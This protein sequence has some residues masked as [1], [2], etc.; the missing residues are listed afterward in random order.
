MGPRHKSKTDPS[1]SNYINTY[2]IRLLHVVNLTIT[3]S[4]VKHSS[5]FFVHY[6]C[7][8]SIFITVFI[9]TIFI[10]LIT[11][12]LSA[13]IS[14]SGDFLLAV[15]ELGGEGLHHLAVL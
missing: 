2:Y 15:D 9:S 14:G 11:V 13:F 5:I 12:L 7:L 8:I 6:S 10:A 1:T 4:I 3:I